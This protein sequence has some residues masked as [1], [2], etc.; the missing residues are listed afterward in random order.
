MLGC[1]L[2]NLMQL[3]RGSV[4]LQTEQIDHWKL[5]K[6]DYQEGRKEKKIAE[7]NF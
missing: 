3:R 5:P 4:N 2:V 7:K 1:S 6:L